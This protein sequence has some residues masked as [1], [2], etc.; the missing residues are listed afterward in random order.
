L[1]RAAREAAETHEEALSQARA[2]QEALFNSMVE[3][4]LVLDAHGRIQ[5]ANQ[6]LRQLTGATHELRGKTV[7]EAFR[8]PGLSELVERA[9]FER[10]VSGVEIE[11]PGLNSRRLQVSASAMAGTDRRPQGMILVF[12]DLTRIRQL[13]N[14]RQDFVA[15]VSHELRT[16]LSLI[17]GYV[18]TLI[19]G[20]KD[21]PAM[22]SRFLQTILK[23]ADRLTYLIEDLLT[24]SQLESGRA[25]LNFQRVELRPSAERVVED[26]AG[27]AAE[28]GVI[29][30]NEVPAGLVAWVDA[31]RMQ[32]VILNLVDNGIKYGRTNGSVEVGARRVDEQTVEMWVKDDGPGIPT[33]SLE[34]IFERFYRVD[35]AR[36]REQGGT[37]L[38]LSIVK[39]IVQSHGGKVWAKSEPGQ[40]S[41]FYFTVADR[42]A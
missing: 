37:G 8:A 42:A 35:R 34:R 36:S 12:H 28:K 1:K 30:R 2:Q 24:L 13:E 22:S 33:E 10:R 29:L 14:T 11:W 7:L 40:G 39:H 9:A 5:L 20:A 25:A 32:Q 18:E 6:A 21:D 31:D 19:D 41:T 16:P 4:V 3:G 26:L 23:H 38:G 27:P 15:N 17:K